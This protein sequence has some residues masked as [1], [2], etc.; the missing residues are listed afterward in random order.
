MCELRFVIYYELYDEGKHHEET[1]TACN[2][3]GCEVPDPHW[4]RV[5]TTAQVLSYV[6]RTV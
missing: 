2:S 3:V 5:G 4:D 6:Y 1:Y